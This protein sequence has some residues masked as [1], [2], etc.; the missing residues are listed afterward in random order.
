MA[1][2]QTCGKYHHIHRDAALLA[3]QRILCLHNDLAL[4]G[5]GPRHVRDLGHLSPNEQGALLQHTLVELIVSLVGGTHVDV[6][7]V[8]VR[9]GLLMHQVGKL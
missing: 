6:E 7:V 2:L 1:R 3:G 8:D 4:F 9:A 5:G